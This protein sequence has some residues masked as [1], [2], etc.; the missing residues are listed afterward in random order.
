MRRRKG[1]SRL[2]NRRPILN[3]PRG[4]SCRMLPLRW[5]DSPLAV[6]LCPVLSIFGG[7]GGGWWWW[8]CGRGYGARGRQGGGWDAG[9]TQIDPPWPGI[10]GIIEARLGAAAFPGI[11]AAKNIRE[12]SYEFSG[13]PSACARTPTTAKRRRD[14]LLRRH[15][16][17]RLHRHGEIARGRESLMF[18]WRARGRV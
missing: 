10:N 6:L 17:H 13:H 5:S 14:S 2:E 11:P 9:R 12:K 3:R 1:R 15:R 7:G 4:R 8:W 18:L 16:L